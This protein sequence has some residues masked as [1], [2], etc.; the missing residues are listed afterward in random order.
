MEVK[1]DNYAMLSN[2]EVLGLLRDIQAGRGQKK[3]N[4][5]Q[6]NLATITYETIKSLENWPCAHHNSEGLTQVMKAL[7]PFKLTPAE[8]LQLINLRPSTA[9]EIQ[10]IVEESEERLTEAQIEELLDLI[11]THLPGSEEENGEQRTDGLVVKHSTVGL[12]VPD[13]IS[14]EGQWIFR[15]WLKSPLYPVVPAWPLHYWLW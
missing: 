10:L 14:G 7:T 3:P 13:S 2:F 6:T 4:K 12:R 1:N 15:S 11:A 8:K 9:V 5:Y